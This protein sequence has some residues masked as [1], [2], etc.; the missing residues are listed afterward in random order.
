MKK[1]VALRATV[2]DVA[3]QVSQKNPKISD[4]LLRFMDSKRNLSVSAWGMIRLT[5]GIFVS[6]VG[7]QLH[8][9][10]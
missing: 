8:M 9:A 3:F 1:D 2:K 10:A 7:F 6:S 5:R 4:I